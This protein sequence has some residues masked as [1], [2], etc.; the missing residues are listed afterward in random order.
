MRGTKEVTA[1][2]Y[3]KYLGCTAQNVSKHVRNNNLHYLPDV[4]QI[5]RYSRFYLLV[6]PDRIKINPKIETQ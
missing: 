2:E 6:V 5:K 3:A 4:I 1:A